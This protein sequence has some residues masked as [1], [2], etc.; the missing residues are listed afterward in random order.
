MDNTTAK[1]ISELL[2]II[3]YGNYVHLD[4]EQWKSFL[5]IIDKAHYWLSIFHEE[6]LKKVNL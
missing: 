4:S 6:E 5:A 1:L 3:N 2:R